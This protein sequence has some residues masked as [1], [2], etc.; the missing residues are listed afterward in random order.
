MAKKRFHV[1]EP[2][3]PFVPKQQQSSLP[4]APT[5]T[6][7]PTPAVVNPLHSLAATASARQRIGD[8]GLAYTLADAAGAGISAVTTATLQGK[9][10]ILYGSESKIP[11][12]DGTEK[13]TK[14]PSTTVDMDLLMSL[15]YF[16]K[17]GEKEPESHAV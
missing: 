11:V 13:A 17:K 9:D 5:T 15:P 7:A 3:P 16:A 8:I 14:R 6:T 4:T 1:K 2:V 10:G 12:G